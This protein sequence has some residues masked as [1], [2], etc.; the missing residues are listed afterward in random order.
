MTPLKT[1]ILIKPFEHKTDGF[2]VN[3]KLTYEKATVIKTGYDVLQI[4]AGDTV[5]YK[6][7]SSDVIEIDGEEFVFIKEEDVI[8][9]S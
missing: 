3:E 2:V 6:N 4:K 8:A 5:Y 9:L 7:Y 1:N